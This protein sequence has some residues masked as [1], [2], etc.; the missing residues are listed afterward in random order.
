MRAAINRP[1]FGTM[2]AALTALIL[3][4]CTTLAADDTA[5]TK[6]KPKS[7][8]GSWQGTL[9]VSGV[10]LRLMFHFGKDEKGN[11]KATLDSP[12]Q[13]AKGIAVD[14]AT[15]SGDAVEVEVKVI[16]GTFEGKLN[17]DGTLIKGQWTQLGNV[18]PLDIKRLDEKP[19]EGRP[20]DPKK[21]YPYNE[22]E[23][24]CENKAAKIKLAGTLTWPKGNGPVPAVLLITGSGPQDRNE[25]VVG[26]KPFLVLADF[27]T[28]RG[29]AVLRL[30]DRGVG[31]STGEWENATTH[32]LTGD[33]LAAVAFLKARKEID[34]RRIGMLGHSEGGLIAPLA[35]S[36]SGDVAF[37]VMMAGTGVNG[38]EILNRQGELLAPILGQGQDAAKNSHWH[39]TNREIIN[40][41]KV[42][43]DQAKAEAKIRD[44]VAK[45]VEHS[46]GAQAELQKAQAEAQL[47]RIL[48]PWMRFFLTYEPRIAL[49]KVRCPVLAINGEKDM[50]VDPKQNLPPLEAALKEGGNKH[51]TVKELPGLNHLFQ[52]CKT[53]SPTEYG[54]IEE[55]IAPEVLE[56]ITTWIVDRTK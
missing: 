30:D 16:Q 13:G 15:V 52:H 46:V 18:L 33:A 40:V 21:P 20:Q 55:T 38:E 3:L 6:S 31:G 47:K 17:E 7:I 39:S 11:L 27:L 56:L 37:I 41:L 32:D 10:E 53:G 45:A 42:E 35:A 4:S 28:R 48:S 29:I 22:E 44:L 24:I 8:D 14:S 43:P 9:K 51:Y 54:A 2:L 36:R 12:N 34:P 26:H 49:R 50:Q 25:S 1:L 23:V 5:T 19:P